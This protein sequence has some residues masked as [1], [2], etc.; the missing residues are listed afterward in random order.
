MT[1]SPR[2]RP[3]YRLADLLAGMRYGDMPTAEDWKDLPPV[4]GEWVPD[5]ARK[6]R[7][8]PSTGRARKTK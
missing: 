1:R 2:A 5:Q 7:A 4:G 3:R 6:A 8:A